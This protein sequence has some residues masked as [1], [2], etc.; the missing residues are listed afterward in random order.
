[1]LAFN[2]IAVKTTKETETVGS[3]EIAPLP[4]G[5]G[6]TLANSLRRVL[7]SSLQGAGMTSVK[8]KDVKHEYTAVEGVKE[9][10]VEVLLNL[11]NVRFKSLSD[12]PQ[13]CYLEAS[14]EKTVTAKMIKTSSNVEVLNPDVVI[15]HL[16][17]KSSN[18]SMELVV[19]KGAGYRGA[20]ESERAEI[21]RIPMDTDFSPITNVKIEVGKARK[22]QETE[23]DSVLIEITTDGSIAPKDALMQAARILQDFSGNIMVA[24]GMSRLEVEQLAEASATAPVEEVAVE[25]GAN[26][27][28]MEWKIEDLAISKRSKTGLLN[29]GYEKV[30]DLVNLT[31]KDLAKLPG[32]GAKSLNEVVSML[33]QSGII[34]K[35]E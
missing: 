16:T 34:L 4:K 7:L 14:G 32:F 28:V 6:F 35:E 17:S 33:E 18:L 30:A 23:L 13:V 12:E 11:K 15:A 3:F 8:I 10:M 25:A 5:Y 31:K 20:Q 21:G 27:E 26:N 22:G 2:D 1:M 19:E 29:G 24:L 9:D